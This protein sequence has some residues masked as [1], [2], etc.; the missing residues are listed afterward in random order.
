VLCAVGVP[1]AFVLPLLACAS[2]VL[3]AVIWFIPDRRIE[4]AIG[5]K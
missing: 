2:Y 4:K 1:L 3:V 5:E